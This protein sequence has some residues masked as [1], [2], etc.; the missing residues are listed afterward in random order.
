M[1]VLFLDTSFVI[2]L[3][4]ADDQYHQIAKHYTAGNRQQGT[5]N[6]GKTFLA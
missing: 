5:G 4:L 2:A 1:A 6:R 3:E